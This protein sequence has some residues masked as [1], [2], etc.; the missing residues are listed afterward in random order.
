MP[1]LYAVAPVLLLGVQ[2][3]EHEPRPHRVQIRVGLVEH[4]VAAGDALGAHVHAF[5]CELLLDLQEPLDLPSVQLLGLGERREYPLDPEVWEAAYLLYEV[6][7][8]APPYAY[9]SETGVHLHPQRRCLTELGGG[10]AEHPGRLRLVDGLAYAEPH[11]G[12]ELP[13]RE[14]GVD[15]HDANVYPRLPYLEGLMELRHEHPLHPLRS[16][17]RHHRHDA[18]AV[19]VGFDAWNDLPPRPGPDLLQVV[20]Y[21]V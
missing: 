21:S 17:V 2:T 18:V 11:D 14:E 7:R 4:G 8:L 20:A 19:G 3:Q 1:E 13:W 15:V 10:V 9:P 12:L 5:G 6:R 16:H